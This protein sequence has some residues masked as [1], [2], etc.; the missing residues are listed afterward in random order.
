MSKDRGQGGGYVHQLQEHALQVPQRVG[1][2]GGPGPNCQMCLLEG[3]KR[4]V[5]R[6]VIDEETDMIKWQEVPGCTR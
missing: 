4:R 3:G 5:I 1:S 2:K 6:E